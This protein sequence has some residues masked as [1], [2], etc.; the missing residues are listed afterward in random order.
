MRNSMDKIHRIKYENKLLESLKHFPITALIGPRQAGKSTLARCIAQKISNKAVFFDL[1]DIIDLEKLQN[2]KLALDPLD[3]LVVIDEIQR[4]PELFPYLRVLVDKF[5]DRRYLILGSAS[6][7]LIEQASETLAGRVNYIELT[8]FALTE[9]RDLK[10]L[11][12]RGGFPRSFVAPNDIVS[13]DWRKS[14]IQSYLERDLPQLGIK[15]SPPDLYRFWMMLAHYHGNIVNYS[16]IGKSLQI[17][18]TTVRKYISILEDTFMIRCLTPWHENISK[19]QVKSPKLY[20]RDIGILQSLLNIPDL[21]NHPK[22]G[23]IWEG[24]AIEEIIRFHELRKEECYFW[25][26]ING[27]ELDLLAFTGEKRGFEIKY[28]DHPKVTKSMVSAIES[29]KLDGL[30]V[31]SPVN[32]E[33]LLRENIR[34][35]GLERYVISNT[36]F[37]HS[38]L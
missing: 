2:I 34:V 30:T 18:D 5:P 6:R 32:D 20:I 26:T 25:Q 38:A 10:R 17:S 23:S 7:D 15:L 14:Y 28:S 19:R 31:I 29:L 12:S 21:I 8:P 9:T 16:E 35:I 13:L 1:E 33:Y 3:T 22:M 27:A 37:V 11:M 4:K 36:F 24:F